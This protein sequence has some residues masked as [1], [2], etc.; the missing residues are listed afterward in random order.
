MVRCPLGQSQRHL[1]SPQQQSVARGGPGLEQAWL[2]GPR[3]SP[4]SSHSHPF[5][6]STSPRLGV[7]EAS[8]LCTPCLQSPGYF[9]VFLCRVPDLES[10]AS[11]VSLIF[12]GLPSELL[13]AAPDVDGV[14]VEQLKTCALLLHSPSRR[15]WSYRL[16][17]CRHVPQNSQAHDH[18]LLPL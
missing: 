18:E 3:A 5:L 15:G 4:A 16:R 11:S 9:P 1:S 7:P 6:R 13:S 14:Y 12:R 8:L 2:R 17:A 10:F